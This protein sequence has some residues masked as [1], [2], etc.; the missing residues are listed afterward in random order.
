MLIL[1]PLVPSVPRDLNVIVTGPTSITVSWSSP[2]S[3]N[4]IL[5]HYNV[6]LEREI[7]G[8]FEPH[9]MATVPAI[10]GED[11]YSLPFNELLAFTLYRIAVSAETRI[12]AGPDVQYIVTTDPSA[13]SPPSFVSAKPLNST[14]IQLLWGYPDVPRGEITGYIIFHNMTDAGEQMNIPLSPVND[15][16]NQTQVFGDLLP[17]TYYE[18]S[19]GAVAVTEEQTHF[20]MPSEPVIVRTPEDS[21]TVIVLID[22]YTCASV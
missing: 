1:F 7:D 13:A 4:G 14:S 8:S 12:G 19:V 18:F 6:V 17:F 3:P 11:S 2:S 15:M 21:K 22:S 20:G 10:E 5:L 16:Q 9:E